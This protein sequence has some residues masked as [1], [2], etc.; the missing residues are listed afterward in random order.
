MQR[1]QKEQLLQTLDSLVEGHR[2]VRRS[3]DARQYDNALQILASCQETALYIGDYI[4]SLT[5]NPAPVL[6]MIEDYCESLYGA[7][8][9]CAEGKASKN[10]CKEPDI[11]LKMIRDYAEK[12]EAVTEIVFLPYQASM[13]DSME[14]VWMAA[15]NHKDCICRVIPLPYY[16]KNADGTFGELQYEGMRFPP[17]VP[18]ILYQDYDL[19]LNH[20]DVIIIHNPYDELNLV[21]SVLPQYYSE[22]LK[23]YTELLVYIPYFVSLGDVADHYCSMPGVANADLVILQS[24]RIR[25]AYLKAALGA[26]AATERKR[27]E[28][29]CKKKFVALGSPKFDRTV[30]LR[31]DNMEI[32]AAWEAF[33]R[34]K[35]GVDA[36]KSISKIPVILYNTHIGGL[37]R[38]GEK[39]LRKLRCVFTYFEKEDKAV[40]L[41]RPHPLSMQ[42]AKSMRP[43]LLQSYRELEEAFRKNEIGI[44][45][46]SAD[47]LKAVGFADAYYGDTSSLMPLF[48]VTGKPLL[49][50][51][52]RINTGRNGSVPRISEVC[53][54]GEAI[55]FICAN[56]NALFCLNIETSSVTQVG[57]FEE[58]L[59]QD[60]L[61]G[62]II[63]Y[64]DELVFVPFSAQRIAVYEKKTGAFIYIPLEKQEMGGEI[65]YRE[66]AKFYA[67]VR[68]K[69]WVYMFGYTYPAILRLNM[70]TRR[71]EYFKDWFHD[72]AL[73]F[74][75]RKDG[76]FHTGKIV[77][78]NTVLLPFLNADAVLEWNLETCRWHIYPVGKNN[79]GFMGIVSDGTWYW[80]VPRRKGP[81][82][83]WDK[84]A[85]LT[86]EYSGL[87]KVMEQMDFQYYRCVYYDKKIWLFAHKAHK[88][89]VINPET[90]LCREDNRFNAGNSGELPAASRGPRFPVAYAGGR[91]LTVFSAEYGRFLF[92]NG[93]TDEI[94]QI[95]INMPQK[96][97]ETE[98]VY[99]LNRLKDTHAQKENAEDTIFSELK[100]PLPFFIKMLGAEDEAA[101]GKRKNLFSELACNCDGTCGE[102]ILEMILQRLEDKRNDR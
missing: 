81:V 59:K 48:G 75:F 73:R 77:Q 27:K 87:P 25:D 32:P 79:S 58:E 28:K 16:K 24:V 82:L 7:S 3:L 44:I 50:Q 17:S 69:H 13:W 92:H 85:G 6:R 19:A 61:Y 53:E 2:D 97:Y 55:W 37:L 11:C 56:S 62:E 98:A 47:F 36:G 51:D 10:V 20:P 42:T 96:Y 83:K 34:K 89:Y 94:K 12:M 95:E 74:T 23:L 26:S 14:S 86:E 43:Q 39:Y 88:N 46:D 18:V 21:T 102:K 30:C 45:D 64:E 60:F 38:H 15:K 9:C 52:I 91:Y 67:G 70:E 1:K 80:L 76:C 78:Q 31:R 40:L 71:V 49:R 84:A 90:G 5:A 54:D 65:P 99:C 57:S 41:W 68:Y 101:A 22:K 93:D 35:A 66:E 29:R 4:E 72:P 8:L 63:P 33:I 100:L